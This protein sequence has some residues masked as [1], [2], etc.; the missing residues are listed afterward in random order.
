MRRSYPTAATVVIVARKERASHVAF[1]GI[2]AL[3]QTVWDQ[4]GASTGGGRWG[5]GR[6]KRMDLGDLGE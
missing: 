4:A 6:G 2:V 3:W 1:L 5:R